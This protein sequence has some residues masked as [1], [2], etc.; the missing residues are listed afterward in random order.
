MYNIL[1]CNYENK[2]AICLRKVLAIFMLVAVI[3]T[4]AACD[5]NNPDVTTTTAPTTT[6]P[7]TTEPSTLSY[8]LTTNP[9]KTVPYVP[10]TKFSAGDS[11][12]VPSSVDVTGSGVNINVTGVD[13]S[14]PSVNIGDAPI[15]TTLPTTTLPTT[16]KPTTS[17]P[18]TTASVKKKVSFPYAGVCSSD[19]SAQSIVVEVSP[20]G[21]GD[22][23]AN[24]GKVNVVVDGESIGSVPCKITAKKNADG[25]QEIVIDL[26]GKGVVVGS[27]VSCVIPEG[28]LVSS[29]GSKYSSSYEINS[30]YN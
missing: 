8:V 13:P 1:E 4:F 7:T 5:D 6:A 11:V 20:D 21:L 28:F 25:R 12:S 14:K 29:D 2:E 16:T 27:S 19:P 18:T 26:S 10:T 30:T 9:G 23:R 17:K 3:C 24:S 22:I 15:T